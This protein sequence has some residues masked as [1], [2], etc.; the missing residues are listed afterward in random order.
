MGNIMML[1]SIEG[2][3]RRS[4]GFRYLI[5]HF[6]VPTPWYLPNFG[7]RK[8]KEEVKKVSNNDNLKPKDALSRLSI[9]MATDCT[10][11]CLSFNYLNT[12]LP[13][14][15][16]NHD[17]LQRKQPLFYNGSLRSNVA[18]YH[19]Y[20]EPGNRPHYPTSFV[21][22]GSRPNNL[23]LGMLLPILWLRSFL[24]FFF[25]KKTKMATII[26]MMKPHV[27][28]ITNLHP[29]VVNF[30]QI[31]WALGMFMEVSS[32]ENSETFYSI[33]RFCIT[34]FVA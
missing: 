11:S 24:F 28:D 13:I 1:V 16:L 20:L 15:G 29:N 22:S 30:I 12:S 10:Q 31:S 19:A 3:R 32:M 6:V 25:F 17:F 33:L 2:F 4:G 7:G 9:K 8:E 26:E 18:Q 14:D 21:G 34:A 5:P 27:D 23:P